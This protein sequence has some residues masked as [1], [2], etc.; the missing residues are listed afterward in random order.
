MFP[1]HHPAESMTYRDQPAR[2][3]IFSHDGALCVTMRG[4]VLSICQLSDLHVR[5]PG[6]LAY[7][8]VDTIAYVERCVSHIVRLAPPPDAVVITGDLADRGA[9]EE[10]HQVL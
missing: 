4:V 5:P 7:R 3:R 1:E 9:P 10:Y 6:Q 8:R 2:R